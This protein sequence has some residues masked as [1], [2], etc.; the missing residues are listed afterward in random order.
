M[1]VGGGGGQKKDIQ[2]AE[3][4]QRKPVEWRKG[5][6][7][8]SGKEQERELKGGSCQVRTVRV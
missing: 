1:L 7:R 8:E 3:E 6:S 4:N 2:R 5:E